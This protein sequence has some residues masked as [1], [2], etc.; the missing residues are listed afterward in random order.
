MANRPDFFTMMARRKTG[1]PEIVW[2]N[3]ERASG[4]HILKA[5]V[6]PVVYKRGSRKG[7][8]NWPKR[9]RSTE[10]TIV[11]SNAELDAL[12]SEWEAETG[13]CSTCGGDGQEWCGWSAEAG[14]RYR[15]CTACGGSGKAADKKAKAA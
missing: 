9:D 7:K 10:A 6:C 11:F 13:L 4:G 15:Q 1:N 8:P 5:A 14:N 3:W 12:I 2:N